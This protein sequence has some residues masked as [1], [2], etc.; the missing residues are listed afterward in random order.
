[1]FNAVG[2]FRNRPPSLLLPPLLDSAISTLPSSFGRLARRYTAGSLRGA[3]SGRQRA[4]SL[5][6]RYACRPRIDW[7]RA[8][9][10]CQSAGILPTVR[11][12]L[13]VR[14]SG[15]RGR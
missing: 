1:M 4:A 6:P 13:F 10:G 7:H 3:H 9:D 2:A 12:A 15:A 8:T 11:C 14:C 5:V